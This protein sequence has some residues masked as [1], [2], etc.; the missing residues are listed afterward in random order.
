MRP[1]MHRSS[2]KKSNRTVDSLL[3][4]IESGISGCILEEDPVDLL[5]MEYCGRFVDLSNLVSQTRQEQVEQQQQDSQRQQQQYP[6]RNNY[7]STIA[8]LSIKD[9]DPQQVLSKARLTKGNG[10]SSRNINRTNS[11][12]STQSVNKV[13][14]AS[15]HMEQKRRVQRI[16]SGVG[17]VRMTYDGSEEQLKSIFP[18]KLLG[19]DK[20]GAPVKRGIGRSRSMQVDPAMSPAKTVISLRGVGRSNS[21]D[22]PASISAPP[23]V[24]SD[25]PNHR[26]QQQPYFR[27]PTIEITPGV[28]ERLRGSEE[29]LR[30]IELGQVT[31]CDCLVC[32]SC[33]VT[34][35]DAEFVLCPDCKVVSPIV[36]SDNDSSHEHTKRHYGRE[37][38]EPSVRGG[39]GLGVHASTC[40]MVV[41]D[42]DLDVLDESYAG[43]TCV[44]SSHYPSCVM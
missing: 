39:V 20:K 41:G 38:D 14:S 31:I 7:P 2:M 40:G 30:A 4:S 36:L 34:I 11:H 42:E 28:Y 35:G 32:N 13:M 16:N 9:L 21:S 23:L 22:N 10:H 18:T 26:K 33:L 17:A 3:G 25:Y 44:T 12:D 43:G 8:V 6:Q 27:Y 24:T 15:S 5:C 37:L 19:Q 29:T 1:S